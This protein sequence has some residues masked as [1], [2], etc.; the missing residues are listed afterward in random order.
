MLCGH[1]YK[2]SSHIHWAL[3]PNKYMSKN[4]VNIRQ[5]LLKMIFEGSVNPFWCFVATTEVCG[6]FPSDTQRNYKTPT[7]KIR[8]IDITYIICLLVFP[9]KF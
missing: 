6:V 1:T 4:F 5:E 2:A 8:Q 3:K 7:T 9:A